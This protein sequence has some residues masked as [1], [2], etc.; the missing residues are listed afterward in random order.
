MNTECW[1][2]FKWATKAIGQQEITFETEKTKKLSQLKNSQNWKFLQVG[3]EKLYTPT[4]DF[5]KAK[6]EQPEDMANG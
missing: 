3:T 5:W 4:P 6:P 1:R 2:H